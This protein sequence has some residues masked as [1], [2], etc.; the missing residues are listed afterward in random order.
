M[1][2]T[3]KNANFLNKN[4]LFHKNAE[5]FN[6]KDSP[7]K[8]A[9]RGISPKKPLSPFSGQSQKRNFNYQVS[10]NKLLNLSPVTPRNNKNTPLIV[11]TR[12]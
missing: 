5:G 8:A 11:S 4:D 12:R 9:F 6:N 3:P 10:P 7:M 2:Y 1:F